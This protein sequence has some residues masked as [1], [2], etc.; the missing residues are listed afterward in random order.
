MSSA[1]AQ[2]FALAPGT[3]QPMAGDAGKAASDPTDTDK[4]AAKDG[5]TAKEDG[6]GLPPDAAALAFLPP[7]ILPVVSPDAPTP[8]GTVAATRSSPAPIATLLAAMPGLPEVTPGV[9]NGKMPTVKATTSQGTAP[10]GEVSSSATVTGAT[11]ATTQTAATADG[12][13]TAATRSSRLASGSDQQSIPAGPTTVA[14]QEASRATLQGVPSH[15]GIGDPLTMAA[16]SDAKGGAPSSSAPASPMVTGPFP[17][18]DRGRVAFAQDRGTEARATP[19]AES[20]VAGSSVGAPS[21]D[22]LAPVLTAPVSRSA[23][24]TVEQVAR[25]ARFTMSAEAVVA[26]PQTG[27]ASARFVTPVASDAVAAPMIQVGQTAPAM[28]LFANAIH[29]GAVDTETVDEHRPRDLAADPFTS[30]ALGRTDAAGQAAIAPTGGAQQ[31]PLD[32]TQQQWPQDMIDRIHRMREDAATADS[33]IQLSPDA[34]GGI[35]VHIRREGE[36]THIHF[37]AEQAQTATMLAEARPELTRLAE[38]KGLKL[39]QTA[40]DLGQAG[41]D[42][43]QPRQAPPRQPESSRPTRPAFAG[44]DSSSDA[45]MGPTAASTRIA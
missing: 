18:R 44:A 7:P 10:G 34:L 6:N 12:V 17:Q 37:T 28:R 23:P 31:A 16:S 36:A 11:I 1:F 14:D 4:M 39:G 38:D 41:T 8:T 21:S 40:V 27:D 13:G 43:G 20:S 9:P 30:I 3:T 25:A 15:D 29:A 5:S 33:R 2:L 24:G 32:M 35:A 45:D 42:G 26:K 19:I 22:G